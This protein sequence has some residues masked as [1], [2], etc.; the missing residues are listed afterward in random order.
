MRL[1]T[2]CIRRHWGESWAAWDDD[3]RYYSDDPLGHGA[4]EAEAVEDLE[5]KLKE[6]EEA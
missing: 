1:L 5:Q 6:R 4:T 3:T 2:S